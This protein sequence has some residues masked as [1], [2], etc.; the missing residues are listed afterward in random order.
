MSGGLPHTG[1][2]AGPCPASSWLISKDGPWL[3]LGPIQFCVV[4]WPAVDT[5]VFVTKE[6]TPEER[7]VSL[8]GRDTYA[9]RIINQSPDVRGLMDIEISTHLG[10]LLTI[11]ANSQVLSGITAHNCQPNTMQEICVP[12]PSYDSHKCI[13]FGFFDGGVCIKITFTPL[14]SS[15]PKDAMELYER[16]TRYDV[17][18]LVSQE[19]SWDVMDH[20]QAVECSFK[21]TK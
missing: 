7:S 2:L 21:I 3:Q 13:P 20:R 8:G 19:F 15:P 18:P 6:G 17:A 4:P 16:A 10:R 5:P 1:T 9:F 12:L 14:L 11:G